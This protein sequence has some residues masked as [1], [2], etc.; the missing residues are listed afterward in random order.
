MYPKVNQQILIDVVDKNISFKTIIAENG[1]NE[2]LIGIPMVD[3]IGILPNGMEIDVTFRT[4]DD[5]FRFPSEII[6]KK[7]DNIPLYIIRKPHEK[8]IIKIQRRENF[9]VNLN[10]K[11]L[12]NDIE[13]TTVNVSAGGL[14]FSGSDKTDLK[15]GEIMTGTVV[16]PNVQTHEIEFVT[17]QGEIR[18]VYDHEIK[19]LKYFAMQ[20]IEIDPQDQTKIVQ[21]CFEQQRQ[22]RLLKRRK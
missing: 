2:I 17:F 10:L 11:L 7:I 4:G 15:E 13:Y 18:R 19:G 21:S 22:M 12:L 16:V 3:Q 20:F 9:R 6:G 5:M 8:Q 14:L 1:E